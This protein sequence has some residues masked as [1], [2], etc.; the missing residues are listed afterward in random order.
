MVAREGSAP[1]ISGCRPDVILFHHRAIIG[2]RGR[3]C[4]SISAFKGRCPEFP[5]PVGAN[6]QH[7][8]L[9]NIIDVGSR[10]AKDR[11]S[12]DEGWVGLSRRRPKVPFT[13]ANVLVFRR[14]FLCRPFNTGWATPEWRLPQSTWTFR[15]KRKENLQSGFGEKH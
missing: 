8:L 2:C 13:T 6:G 3:I 14:R 15:V 7:S 11:G 1:S 9:H 5:P 12:P 10:P 4:T